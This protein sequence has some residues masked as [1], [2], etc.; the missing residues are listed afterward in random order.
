VLSVK[1]NGMKRTIFVLALVLP[2]PTS[3]PSGP[4]ERTEMY[5]KLWP[6]LKTIDLG[7]SG[8]LV[9]DP[10][11]VVGAVEDKEVVAEFFL[12]NRESTYL[13]MKMESG[14]LPP[15]DTLGIFLTRDPEQVALAVGKTICVSSTGVVYIEKP[16]G[17]NA[18][19]GEYIVQKWVE[20]DSSLQEVEQPFYQLGL[21]AHVNEAVQIYAAPDSGDLVATIG[22]D[23]EVLVVGANGATDLEED[24]YLLRSVIGLVGWHKPRYIDTDS[25]Q[26]S[27]FSL[28]LLD[29][30]YP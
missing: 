13:V 18:F 24:W 25:R 15:F 7:W 16:L 30:M 14:V 2:L 19:V 6:N 22:K 23:S 11:K 28:S 1:E 9:Y 20:V 17:D 3:A 5:L 29:G 21:P 27:H 12:G 8:V 10:G 26:I 4:S